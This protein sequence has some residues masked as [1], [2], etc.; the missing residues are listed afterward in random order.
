VKSAPMI[1][2]LTTAILSNICAKKG[3]NK[4]FS[5]KQHRDNVL[6][7]RGIHP[8]ANKPKSPFVEEKK[9]PK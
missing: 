4:S 7:R 2:A 1:K 3:N 9:G 8:K 6:A 5:S